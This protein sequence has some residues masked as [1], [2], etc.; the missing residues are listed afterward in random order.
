MKIYE[1]VKGVTKANLKSLSQST[2]TTLNLYSL[3][4]KVFLMDSVRNNLKKD[5]SHFLSSCIQAPITS[6]GKSYPTTYWESII[7][8]LN[9]VLDT[10][11]ELCVPPVIIQ[12]F[13]AQVYSDIDVQLFNILLMH[14][15]CCT[16]GNGEYVKSG[17]AKL[18]A[19][20]TKAT[21]KF[22]GILFWINP[23][24]LVEILR[25]LHGKYKIRSNLS[26]SCHW[27]LDVK[28]SYEGKVSEDNFPTT[29]GDLMKTS[30]WV[31]LYYGH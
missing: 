31:M 8:S 16:L 22:H 25:A 7:E 23:F 17:L 12:N 15:E 6:D 9:G 4:Y 30:S 11:K 29:I 28:F 20:C 26:A 14:K 10:L 24:V 5:L 18:E 2:T 3:H 13:F 27:R 21:A 19:W 1:D